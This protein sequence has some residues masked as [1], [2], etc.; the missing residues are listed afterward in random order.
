MS[1][2]WRDWLLVV[3]C[4]VSLKWCFIP[5]SH[6]SQEAFERKLLHNLMV[7]LEEWVR[8]ACRIHLINYQ[9]SIR[10]LKR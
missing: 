3:A 10:L 1:T 7:E 6:Y 5:G 2:G 4:L 9:S 8:E